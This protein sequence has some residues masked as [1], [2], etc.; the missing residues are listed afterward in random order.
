MSEEVRNRECSREKEADANASKSKQ[1]CIFIDSEVYNDILCDPQAFRECLDQEIA[2]HP[3]LFPATI[4]QGYTLH[5]ILP[6]SKKMPGV[7]LRRIKLNVP[8]DETTSPVYTVRPSFVFP[9]MTGLT[10]VIARALLLRLWGVPFWVLAYVF[11]RNAQYWYRL[12]QQVGRYSIVGTT[13]Q[14]PENLPR[15]L[16]ADEK[17][18]RFH[19]D[20][21]YI[22]MTVA[23]ECVLG[24][25]VSLTADEP[26]LTEAYAPFKAEATRVDPEYTPRTVNTDGW[27]ATQ[28]AWRSLF[29]Q[30]TVILCFLH[31]FLNVRKRCKRLQETYTALKTRIWETYHAPDAPTFLAKIAA[32]ETWATHT[33]PE[34]SGLDAVRKL[35]RKAP[36]FAKT[37]AHPYA[38]RTSNMIDRQIRLLERVLVRQQGFHGHLKS[39]DRS[40]RAWALYHNFRPYCPRSKIVETHQSPVD[41]LNGF[42][43]HENWLHNLMISASLGGYR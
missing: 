7:R 24:A 40:C 14:V 1:I 12:E 32:L 27:A 10:T 35:C 8:V 38:Y 41:K 13:V 2:A 31:A 37:Y 11:G 3:Q 42:V 20:K 30:V 25:A 22:A 23:D 21:A 4:A 15:D 33:M 17:H 36:E 39:A 19:G 28:A 16:L 5:D 29:S 26:G 43:Y 34:G 18:T 6:E 9:Y